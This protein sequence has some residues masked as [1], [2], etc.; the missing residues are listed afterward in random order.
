MADILPTVLFP[1]LTSDGT[2]ITIPLS[3]FIGLTA[4]EEDPTSGS[5]VE[6]ARTFCETISKRWLALQPTLRS[7]RFVTNK[8]NPVGLRVDT[9]RQAYTYSFDFRF[10]PST[11][12][13]IPEANGGVTTPPPVQ[14]PQ[15]P[16][17]PPATGVTI[18]AGIPAI[19]TPA[20]T[21]FADLATLQAHPDVGNAVYTGTAWTQNQYVPLLTKTGATNEAKARWTGS[22][23]AELRQVQDVQ[24]RPAGQSSLISPSG[25]DVFIPLTLAELKAHP[26]VGDA[27][28]ASK[29]SSNFW[30]AGMRVDLN[31][32]TTAYWD[33]TAG[34]WLAGVVPTVTTPPAVDNFIVWLQDNDGVNHASNPATVSQNTGV[35]GESSPD[36]SI[37]KFGANSWRR[38]TPFTTGTSYEVPDAQPDVDQVDA[39]TIEGY[40]YLNS[41]EVHSSKISLI[42]QYQHSDPNLSL[43]EQFCDFAIDLNTQDIAD[44]QGFAP[45]LKLV[46]VPHTNQVQ[47]DTWHHL[48]CVQ[49]AT[50]SVSWYVDGQKWATFP[51]RISLKVQQ[52]PVTNAWFIQWQDALMRV[53]DNSSPE[54][55]LDSWAMTVGARYTA[56]FNPV[57]ASTHLN[58]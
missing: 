39:W 7:N 20:G 15:P 38:I 44:W 24:P 41:A 50:G 46:S 48:A 28:Y 11:V 2:N 57:T 31:D 10:D 35:M 26:V 32:G 55:R 52:Q 54:L 3:D 14:A 8:A 29:N 1:N 42:A 12:S 25:L 22:A 34:A 47:E 4:G 21:T 16:Q 45:D 18:V 56:N 19:V 49:E 9:A 53:G 33:D 58:Y 6:V 43:E 23:W 5:G 40:F 17:T 13:V 37:F 27:N 51:T 36:T 30:Q